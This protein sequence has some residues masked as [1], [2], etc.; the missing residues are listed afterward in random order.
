MRNLFLIGLLLFVGMAG[1]LFGL[2]YIINHNFDVQTR[3]V[4]QHVEL[5]ACHRLNIVRAN[6]NRNQFADYKFDQLFIHLIQDT[7]KAAPKTHGQQRLTNEFLGGLKA[8]ASAKEW[9]PLTNCPAAVYKALVAPTPIKFSHKY[10]P[11]D[12]LYLTA[13]N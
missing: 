11:H 6:D 7:S 10:P 1:G 3:I 5:R 12:A 4:A 13:V 2:S 8:Q 9:I